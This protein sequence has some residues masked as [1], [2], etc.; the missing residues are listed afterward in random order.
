[1]GARN[2]GRRP[3]LRQNGVCFSLKS[4]FTDPSGSVAISGRCG[5]FVYYDFLVRYMAAG[6]GCGP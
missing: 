4:I 1:M 5:G 2:A 3:I 6:G